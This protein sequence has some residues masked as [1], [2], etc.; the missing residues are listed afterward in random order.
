MKRPPKAPY[1]APNSSACNGK[2]LVSYI[3]I[4]IDVVAGTSTK[5][6]G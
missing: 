1:E 4:A 2:L 3:G 6:R 5:G